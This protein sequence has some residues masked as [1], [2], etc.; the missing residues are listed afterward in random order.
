MRYSRRESYFTTARRD[1][2]CPETNVPIRKGDTIVYS[3]AYRIAYAVSS[4]TADQ[5]RARQ[6]A[7]AFNMD[8]ANY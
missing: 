8:D 2:V 1:S 5:V 7:Q 4:K 6:F 3:P